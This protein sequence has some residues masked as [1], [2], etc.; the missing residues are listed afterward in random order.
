MSKSKHER[1]YDYERAAASIL[2]WLH[3]AEY[4]LVGHTL[5]SFNGDVG[6]CLELKLDEAHGLVFKT[7]TAKRWVPVSTIKLY[8]PKP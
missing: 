6:V 7:D 5:T 8:G 1:R 2:S 3:I 4:D